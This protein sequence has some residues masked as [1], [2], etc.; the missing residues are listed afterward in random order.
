M[1][2]G[3]N[4][5]RIG[6]LGKKEGSMSSEALK[7][8]RP[9]Y[10]QSEIATYLKCAKQWE[11]RYVQGIKTPPKAALTVG[12]SVDAAVTHNLVEK[13]K[14]GADLPAEAVLDAYSTSFDKRST[15]TE[16]GEDDAG[17]QKDIGI[18]LVKLHHE[19]IAPEIKPATVQEE[20]I[21]QTDAGYDL[22]GTIDFTETSGVIADTKTSKTA[23]DSD[24]ISRALQPALY[25]FAY[26]ALHQ[27][28]AEGFRYDVLIKPTKT[29][30]AASQRVEGKVTHDDREW[31]F[32]TINNVHKAIQAGVATP[33]PD[34]AWWCS[35][36]WCGYGAAGY[37]KK[38][39]R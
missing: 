5:G 21:I 35:R 32:D 39:Q 7:L 1:G 26:E 3:L 8:M 34:G 24:A 14:T 4:K 25:D 20:F 6:D 30:P 16:W 15:E 9:K 33:A 37:C 36:E 17:K 12:S 27:K 23:Y 19:K 2:S 11:F 31:L 28:P 29:K 38:F 13:I 18:Q 22:G 10:H